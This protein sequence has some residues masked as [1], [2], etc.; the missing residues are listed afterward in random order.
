M[1]TVAVELRLLCKLANVG[2]TVSLII[3]YTVTIYFY[4]IRFVAVYCLEQY[5][6][7]V[8]V[9]QADELA[10]CCVVVAII[11]DVVIVVFVEFVELD[12][13]DYTYVRTEY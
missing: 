7:V 4:L 13:F 11:V 5:S 2:S 8:L 3:I 6:F 1:A 12:E 9:D 10:G